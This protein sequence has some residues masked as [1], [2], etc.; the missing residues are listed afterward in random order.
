MFPFCALLSDKRYLSELVYSI[1]VLY[2]RVV[3]VW[4]MI[5]QDPSGHCTVGACAGT[6]SVVML[7]L[8]R[9]NSTRAI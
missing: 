1:P 3:G 5:I 2:S 6:P 9:R 8:L 7:D 4:S